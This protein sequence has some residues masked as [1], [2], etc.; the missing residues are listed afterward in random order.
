MTVYCKLDK[1][2]KEKEMTY[3]ALS[4]KT[5]VSYVALWKLAN[6]KKYNPSYEVI[7]NICRVL[8]CDIGDLLSLKKK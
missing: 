5:G 1:L 3:K 2:L 4:K 8:K 7:E 6:G